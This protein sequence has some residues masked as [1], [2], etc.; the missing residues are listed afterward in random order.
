MKQ[1]SSGTLERAAQPR[2]KNAPLCKDKIAIGV[3][4]YDNGGVDKVGGTV[5][6]FTVVYTGRYRRYTGG[7]QQYV[8]MSTNPFSPQ[9]FG[10]HGSS[11]TGIDRPAYSHLGKRIAFTDL[12]KDCQRLVQTDCQELA[13]GGADD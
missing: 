7:E 5:D 12:P 11:R 2:E 10:Q 4:C 9:G 8:G 3:R 6:R 1:S 13:K